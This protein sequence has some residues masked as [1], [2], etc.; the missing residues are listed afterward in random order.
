MSIIIFLRRNYQV[1]R[2]YKQSSPK[3][4]NQTEKPKQNSQ[5]AWEEID[6]DKINY[7][8]KSLKRKY[9]R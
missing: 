2:S 7:D 6:E 3:K 1:S 9:D 4:G 8:I 5:I